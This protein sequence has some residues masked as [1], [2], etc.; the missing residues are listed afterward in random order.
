MN[1]AMGSISGKAALGVSIAIVWSLDEVAAS[2]P[3]GKVSSICPWW[4]PT[5]KERASHGRAVEVADVDL[6][7]PGARL[8]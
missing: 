8:Q 4:L 1:T 7:Q 5:I 2:G 6:R 3:P